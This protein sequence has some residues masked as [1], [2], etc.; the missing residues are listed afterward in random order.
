MDNR[1]PASFAARINRASQRAA[2][3]HFF[4]AA[5]FVIQSASAAIVVDP[6][7]VGASDVS[8][9]TSASSAV[10]ISNPV[11]DP[12]NSPPGNGV[13]VVG[14]TS[15]GTL[16]I[17]AGGQANIQTAWIGSA[18][19]G[20]PGLLTVRDAGSKL[21]ASSNVEVG[22]G[23]SGYGTLEI[24]EGA[25]VQARTLNIDSSQVSQP[26]MLLLDGMGSKLKVTS[27]ISVSRNGIASVTNGA[28]LETYG[29][30]VGS[31]FSDGDVGKVT[32]DGGNS[33]WTVDYQ[34]TVGQNGNGSLTISN[35][36]EVDA[37][38]SMLGGDAGP[39]VALT[40]D[41]GTLRTD[42]LYFAQGAMEG[43]GNVLAKGMVAD[44]P[45]AFD[46]T[47]GLIQQIPVAGQPQVM[48]E[49]AHS[50]SGTLGAGFRGNGTL[51]I[52]DSKFVHSAV[53]V[54][55][56]GPGSFGQAT[57]TGAGS[58]WQVD[59]DLLLGVDGD[60][61]LKIGAGGTV[62]VDGN[63]QLRNRSEGTAS[64]VLLE[65]GNLSVNVLA[66]S[67]D[68]LQGS[69]TI[70]AQAVNLDAHLAFD[71]A[72]PAPAV[73]VLDEL[74]GQQVT[75]DF[76]GDTLGSLGVGYRGVG[77]LEIRNGAQVE[78]TGG[79][80]GK[81][82]GS[83][84]SAVV[85]GVD[86]EW[87]MPD[88]QLM[89]GSYNSDVVGELRV[90]G[91]GFVESRE[92]FLTPSGSI[93]VAGLNSRFET[94]YMQFGG[95][96]NGVLSSLRIYSGGNVKTS[97]INSGGY[98][99]LLIEGADSR[100]QVVSYFLMD[101][102][103]IR[104]RDGGTLELGDE[105]G[106][107]GD[108]Q[109]RG[110]AIHLDGGNVE[111]YGGTIRMEGGQFLFEEGTLKN[112]QRFEG[113]LLQTGGRV[114]LGLS[115][116]SLITGT[117][118]QDDDATLQIVF[119]SQTSQERLKVNG[120]A[121]IGGTLEVTIDEQ[122]ELPTEAYPFGGFFPVLGSQQGILGTFENY[123]LPELATGLAWAVD[124]YP[125][126]L[127]LQVIAGDY[128]QDGVV[129]AADYTVWRNSLHQQVEAGSGADGDRDGYID[130]DDFEVWKSFFGRVVVDG[131]GGGAGAAAGVPEPA[132]CILLVAGMIVSAAMRRRGR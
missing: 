88:G 1:M 111:L 34:L 97:S 90:L 108:F 65:G 98:G 125:T 80:L 87:R 16:E 102:T 103:L 84:G 49:L 27:Y 21:T 75:I 17:D 28:N 60:G 55:G 7:S 122:F 42:A 50:A 96:N 131:G 18:S 86:S 85:E 64:R 15:P 12:L 116:Q 67:V 121:V 44:I 2:A 14:R 92:T 113:D 59:G 129:G 74:P 101:G 82:I 6:L 124:Q 114:E 110:G 8:F 91:G 11:A 38:A 19:G 23:S 3:V 40:L 95:S 70:H 25:S 106:P 54:L 52:T 109:L 26:S 117:Y 61:E 5:W 51:L 58:T 36:A 32:I 29:A 118:Y 37:A 63:L 79:M 46:A 69:G 39:A 105:F 4:L 81:E 73:L 9:G 57:V 10:P 41:G 53:G 35:G 89:V 130:E 13:L 126:G 120:A 48:F 71:E 43:A 68:Q 83:H 20:S 94:E 132:S 45:L 93:E 56:F 107:Q 99:D 104:V 127:A 76:D 77:S 62:N 123:V 115:V 31:S 72:G 100:L 22:S 112:F 33:L 24:V 66:A 78:S 119:H 47:H 30:R 128:N